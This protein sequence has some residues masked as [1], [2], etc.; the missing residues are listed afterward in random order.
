MF[1]EFFIASLTVINPK[2]PVELLNDSPPKLVGESSYTVAAV[3][4]LSS[5]PGATA[6]SGFIHEPGCLFKSDALFLP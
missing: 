3:I 1:E 2:Y 6:A 5:N 4:T